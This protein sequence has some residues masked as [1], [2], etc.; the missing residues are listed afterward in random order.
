MLESA[1]PPMTLLDLLS[2][3]LVLRQITPH[4]GLPAILRLSA[5]SR[6]LRLLVYTPSVLRYL[7][8]GALRAA[9]GLFAAYR[10]WG[11]SAPRRACLQLARS[12]L[13]AGV[14]TLV[15]DDLYVDGDLIEDILTGRGF[16]VR[17]LSVRE[18][19][20]MSVGQV[21]SRVDAI[22]HSADEGTNP[23][24]VK[25]LYLCSPRER[26]VVVVP[27]HD[28][29][30]PR[31]QEDAGYS[32][33]SPSIPSDRSARDD[34]GSSSL[35]ADARN[36]TVVGWYESTGRLESPGFKLIHIDPTGAVRNYCDAL[37]S[38]Q[39]LLSFDAVMCRGPRHRQ[40][41]ASFIQLP[42]RPAL[43]TIALGSRGCQTCH[44]S[45]EGPAIFGSS[46]AHHLPLVSPPP[47]HSA[48]LRAAQCPPRMADGTVPPL[49]VRC[50]DCMRDRWCEL[51]NKWWCEDCYTGC[52]P[53]RAANPAQEDLMLGGRPERRVSLEASDSLE[54]SH[55]RC[56]CCLV[57]VMRNRVE[58]R[59]STGQPKA[60]FNIP[61][62]CMSS[63]RSPADDA[64]A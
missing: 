10:D 54:V 56:D 2:T 60:P 32:P 37:L 28:G 55:G 24:N 25:G 61:F 58:V 39:G 9:T 59:L 22:A 63:I 33:P 50:E 43:A 31:V 14:Q 52:G 45:P 7:D 36:S 1:A 17:I 8:L 46:P 49:F 38:C 42:L 13:L 44:S 23:F 18:L 5:T 57:L 53:E 35:T 26:P 64:S 62:F 11:V 19:R 41:L 21:L 34:A 30:T 27:A 20:C 4:L 16:N 6:S 48:T 3:S 12:G 15:L 29:R 40:S 47:L 51:C